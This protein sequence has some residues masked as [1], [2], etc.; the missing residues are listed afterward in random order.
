M[1]DAFDPIILIPAKSK[2]KKWKVA[3]KNHVLLML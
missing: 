3:I 2:E 1:T